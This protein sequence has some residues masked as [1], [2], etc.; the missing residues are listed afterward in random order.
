MVEQV[1]FCGAHSDVGGGYPETHLSDI[2][3]DWMVEKAQVAGLAFDKEAIDALPA[4]VESPWDATQFQ[5]GVLSDHR[6]DQPWI[7][8]DSGEGG[9]PGRRDLTQ[10]V[11]SRVRW[12]MGWRSRLSAQGA[13]GTP[14]QDRRPPGLVGPLTAPARG[15]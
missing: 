3:L 5:D 1:W 7:G 13:A 4:P 15:P 11:H 8:M 6:G 9:V 14:G 10:S 2:A 12:P